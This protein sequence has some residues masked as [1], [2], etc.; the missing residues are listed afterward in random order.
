MHV[1]GRR[2]P[3]DPEQEIGNHILSDLSMENLRMELDPEKGQC[4]VPHGRYRAGLTVSYADE[5]L[6][7]GLYPVTMAHPYLICDRIRC[8]AV[9]HVTRIIN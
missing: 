5:I 6:G 9:K 7:Q 8:K 2:A 4:P 3:A 1:P